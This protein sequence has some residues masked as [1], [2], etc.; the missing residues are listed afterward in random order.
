MDLTNRD[1][2]VRVKNAD[3]WQGDH[4]VISNL[5]FE[6]GKGEFMYL[7]GKTGSGKSSV[8]RT[9]YADLPLQKGEAE[10]A[11]YSLRQLTPAQVPL[12]RRKLGIVFQDFQLFPDRTVAENLLFVMRATGWSGRDKMKKQL[13]SVLMMVGM[14]ASQHKMPHQLSGGEQQRVAIARALI[15]EPH[16][17]F[18]DEPTGNLD[19]AVSNEILELFIRINQQVGTAVLMATHNHAFLKRYPARV[20]FCDN[21]QVKDFSRQSLLERI[22]AAA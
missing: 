3:I 1:T 9:L 10:V 22:G 13:S 8:L 16:V 4:L 17:L 18:A 14:E 5:N 6:I 20:L 15:N 7:V 21:Q 2:V 11:G 19:P 12:M